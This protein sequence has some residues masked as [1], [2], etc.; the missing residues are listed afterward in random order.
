MR[1]PWPN[2]LY[3][4]KKFLPVKTRT[5]LLRFVKTYTALRENEVSM[6]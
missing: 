1:P 6:L 5:F 4:T 2:I 3:Q